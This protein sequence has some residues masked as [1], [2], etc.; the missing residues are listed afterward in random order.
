MRAATAAIMS[1][2]ALMLPSHHFDVCLVQVPLHLLLLPM[3]LADHC[4]CFN[5][6]AVHILLLPYLLRLSLL[7]CRCRA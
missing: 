7:C 4:R 5:A 2:L 6:P 3:A 1:H